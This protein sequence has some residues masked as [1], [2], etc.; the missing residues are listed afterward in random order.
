[1]EKPRHMPR[2]AAEARRFGKIG[3]SSG[4]LLSLPLWAFAWLDLVAAS[5]HGADAWTVSSPNGKITV[6][7]QQQADRSLT[8]SVRL[9]DRPVV[10]DSPLGLFIQFVTNSGRGPDGPGPHNPCSA[11]ASPSILVLG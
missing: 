3:M 6:N 2:H 10:E 11:P 9:D 8:C 1:M 7:I 5:V 4:K